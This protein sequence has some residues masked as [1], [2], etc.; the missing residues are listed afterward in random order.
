VI[1]YSGDIAGAGR[2]NLSGISAGSHYFSI[3]PEHVN[4]QATAFIEINAGKFGRGLC[5]VSS[6][7]GIL[8]ILAA[9][10]EA[11]IFPSIIE[12]IAVSMV[13]KN[14]FWGLHNF[15]RQTNYFCFF[16]T[17]PCAPEGIK[18]AFMSSSEIPF[19]TAEAV[20]ILRVQNRP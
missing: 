2:F 19:E 7:F 20:I 5:L 11:E 3:G 15:P 9:G 14:S 6:F 16:K 10:S 13:N 18:F 4:P 1:F 8:H 12:R 17:N